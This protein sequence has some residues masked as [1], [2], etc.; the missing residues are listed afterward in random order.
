VTRGFRLPHPASE[1][2]RST[3]REANYRVET[4]HKGEW[5]QEATAEKENVTEA[6]THAETV[7]KQE[8]TEY[9]AQ[10]SIVCIVVA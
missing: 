10:C 4:Q 5:H 9:R 1:A 3:D 7:C 2:A 8:E 6:D